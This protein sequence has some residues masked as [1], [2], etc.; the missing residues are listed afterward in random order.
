MMSVAL[1]A[2]EKYARHG[3]RTRGRGPVDIAR[4]RDRTFMDRDSL[5]DRNGGRGD[6]R[7][8]AATSCRAHRSFRRRQRSRHYPAQS[9]RMDD[10]PYRAEI[11][12]QSADSASDR[13]SV[14]ADVEDLR[15]DLTRGCT[16]PMSWLRKV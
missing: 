14:D 2:R 3:Q 15:A 10:V 13:R 6:R 7:G 5:A 9:G 16:K 8:I 11:R 12:G 1:T 4:F